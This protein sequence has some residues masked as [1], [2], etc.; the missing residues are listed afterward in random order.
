M[1]AGKTGPRLI[2]LP[3]YAEWVEAWRLM[4]VCRLDLDESSG[5][6]YL[7]EQCCTGIPPS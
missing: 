2:E 7:A 4:P 5:W 3:L 6:R 1:L